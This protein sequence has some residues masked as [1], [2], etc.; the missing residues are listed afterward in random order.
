MNKSNEIQTDADAYK[1]LNEANAY[2]VPSSN[3]MVQMVKFNNYQ[4]GTFIPNGDVF[5]DIIKDAA[6]MYERELEEYNPMKKTERENK[7]FLHSSV[8]FFGD[9][10][11]APAWEQEWYRVNKE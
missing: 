10:P 2:F 3:D 11:S 1:W 8:G 6:M 7:K 9:D 4:L 5:V